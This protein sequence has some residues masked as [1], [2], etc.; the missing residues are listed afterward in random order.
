MDLLN[1]LRAAWAARAKFGD[2]SCEAPFVGAGGADG[3]TGGVDRTGGRGADDG[4]GGGA[5]GGMRLVVEAEVNEDRP[6]GLRDVGGG[7]GGFLPS[8]G[9]LGFEDGILEDEAV[10]TT[11][12]GLRLFRS[13][14]TF[15]GAGA[16]PGG[17]GGA[18]PGTRGAPGGLGAEPI[19]GRGTDALDV[20]GS[21][22]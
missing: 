10:D 18:L 12:D 22:R 8:I 1:A 20:S 5:L 9:G 4:G 13:A 11:D 7:M 3:G 6:D 15:G 16:A 21:E 14:A 19:G 17:G 2:A